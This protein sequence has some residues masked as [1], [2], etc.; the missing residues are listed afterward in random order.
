MRDDPYIKFLLSETE[1]LEEKGIGDAVGAK[2]A[3][4]GD[5]LKNSA[6]NA[7]GGDYTS[8]GN[9]AAGQ[10][11]VINIAGALRK[12]W[13][14][15]AGQVKGMDIAKPTPN[16]VATWIK[17]RYDLDIKLPMITT[18]TEQTPV[19]DE[20]DSV[21]YATDDTAEPNQAP[22]PEEAAPEEATVAPTMDQPAFDKHLRKTLGDLYKFKDASARPSPQQK[23]N[24][25]VAMKTLLQAAAN[26]DAARKQKVRD[27]IEPLPTDSVLMNKFPEF[28]RLLKM[29]DLTE[30]ALY[31]YTLAENAGVSQMLAENDIG[32]LEMSRRQLDKFF[33]LIAQK[34]I[35][36]GHVSDGPNDGYDPQPTERAPEQKPNRQEDRKSAEEK[37]SLFKHYVT[38]IAHKKRYRITN[39]DRHRL[40]RLVIALRDNNE[41]NIETA[42]DALN[43]DFTKIVLAA[44]T[45]TNK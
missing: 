43:P 4:F 20:D 28:E 15:Y 34:M 35:A 24:L 1:R 12:E 14:R 41:N 45:A 7:V 33:K 23:K 16:N 42:I 30:S 21:I 17:K 38:D 18:D 6:L 9:K 22:E 25:L 44:L 13:F 39:D 36:D 2:L 37:I 40:N 29:Y 26:G 5:R 19:A 31:L 10:L 27:I 8:F 11:D 3:R 32:A